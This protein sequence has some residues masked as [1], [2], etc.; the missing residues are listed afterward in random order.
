[1]ARHGGIPAFD[2]VTYANLGNTNS[3]SPFTFRDNQ[4]TV[5]A[6]VTYVKGSHSIRAGGEYIHAA[7][8]HEQPG[9]GSLVIPRGGFLFSGG[10]TTGTGAT[11]TQANS[12]ADFLLGQAYNYG[13]GV[14]SFNPEALRITTFAFYVQDTW[15]A[16][17]TLVLNY[18]VR[19]ELY[20]LPVADHFGTVRYDPSIRSTVT[21]AFGTHT[22]GTVLVGSEGSEDKHVTTQN[23]Y[24]QF[25][26]R[27]GISYQAHP[28]TVLRGGFGI[29]ADPDN[30]R[31]L[32][33]A[34]PANISTNVTGINSLVAASS[35]NP[36]LL[37]TTTQVGIPV[38]VLP[39]ITSGMV[40][41]PV[42]ISTET[43]LPQFR[44]GYIE[45]YNGSFQHEFP[46][47]FVVTL[48][49]VGTHAIRQITHVNLNPA[50]PG[51]GN[52]GRL[53]NTTY[54][55]NTSNTDIFAQQ[56]FGS[57]GYNAL[58][59]QVTRNSKHGST[60]I[61]YTWSKAFD[62]SDNSISNPLTFAYPSV[63]GRNYALAGYDRKHNFQWWT[64]YPL[65]FGHDGL[66]LQHGVAGYI[67]GNWRVGTILSRVSGTPFTVTAS[68]TSL[69]A[70]G[71]T[72]VADQ[73]YGVK[74]IIGG[75]A[76]LSGNGGSYQ[77]LNAAAFAP[78]SAVR[79][80]T[81]SRNDVRG[82]GLFDLD[83]SVKREFPLY[84][85]VRLELS[86][87]S[88]DVTNTPAFANPAANISNA[89]FGQVITSNANRSI[90]LSGR[91]LF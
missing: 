23:G 68:G 53:L 4:Y 33:Q 35:I 60:G 45:S 7:I 43:I 25:V 86:A 80:G 63:Y 81:A 38:Q 14:Q 32:L 58:Q 50:P 82:P 84:E 77:Y 72:Q 18:G 21:D 61:I 85:Q 51:G 3:G 8:N 47:N 29:T 48:A 28:R 11:T 44:R 41:L 75:R 52:A 76:S 70:P 26:P 66:F 39:S 87:D 13:K 54:G 46:S 2:F 64:S 78:V 12:F 16:T 10:V 22:V 27:L 1:M 74:S 56:P 67:L 19:Y 71:S 6:N 57:S 36:G 90:R 79:F 17:K 89:G 15:Q 73:N 42:T 40:P 30:L 59:T 49:Y 83:V 24:G 5:N 9:N 20:P 62:V 88:F 91:I 65:P 31:N 55:A 34:Y 37:S 69:N